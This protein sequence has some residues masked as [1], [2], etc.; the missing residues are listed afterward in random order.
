MHCVLKGGGDSQQS[1]NWTGPAITNN[2]ATT[3]N[4]QSSSTFTI[5]RVQK[6]DGGEY[7]CSYLGLVIS[8]TLNVVCKFLYHVTNW[9][10][11]NIITPCS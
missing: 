6:K 8:F 2:R 5:E 10:T 9:T 3:N 1:F 7:R 11:P 4:G